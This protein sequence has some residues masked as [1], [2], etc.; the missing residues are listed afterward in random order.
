MIPSAKIQTRHI[1]GHARTYAGPT[2]CSDSGLPRLRF[3]SK[4]IVERIP[5]SLPYI[6][7]YILVALL[8]RRILQSNIHAVENAQIVESLLRREEFALAQ[9]IAGMDTN[10]PLHNLRT[11]RP[12][13][14]DQHFIHQHFFAF[15]NID[16]HIHVVRLRTGFGRNIEPRIW[17]PPVHVFRQQLVAVTGEVVLRIRLAFRAGD[18]IA[19]LFFG[20]GTIAR[21]LRSAD[22]SLRTFFYI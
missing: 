15:V 3:K 1:K 20:N 5:R 22:Q 8:A 7:Q 17:V 14:R 12:Q 10:L 11:R 6:N 9:W 18:L 13:A 16:D 19:Q 2:L 21:K 4:S